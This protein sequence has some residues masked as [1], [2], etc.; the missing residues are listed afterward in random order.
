MLGHFG[1]DDGLQGD[2][3]VDLEFFENQV[4]SPTT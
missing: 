1:G 2:V 4:K 3:I